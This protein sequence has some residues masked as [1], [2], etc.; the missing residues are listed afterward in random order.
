MKKKGIFVFE[1][2]SVDKAIVQRKNYFRKNEI[3]SIILF[4][5]LGNFVNFAHNVKHLKNVNILNNV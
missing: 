1:I 3:K 5:N 4:V 2:P